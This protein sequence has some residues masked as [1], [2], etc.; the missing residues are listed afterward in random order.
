[1]VSWKSIVPSLRTPVF[2]A[3]D[4]KQPQP[5]GCKCYN[6]AAL[7]HSILKNACGDGLAGTAMSSQESGKQEILNASLRIPV[8]LERGVCQSSHQLKLDINKPTLHGFI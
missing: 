4:E 6:N 1:M 2:Q 7:G 8:S 5:L 3:G